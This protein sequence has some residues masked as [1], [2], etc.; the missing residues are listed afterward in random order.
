MSAL[1]IL[2]KLIKESEGCK[3]TS[4]KCPAGIWTIGYGQ[5]KGIKEGM[6]WTQNQADE[7]L[8]KSAL[9]VLNRAIKYSPIL[10]TVNMEKQ[11]AIA[12]FIYNLGVGKYATSTLKKK[13][14]VGDW[15][16]AASEIKRWDKAAGKVLKG[17]TVR[18]AKEAALLLE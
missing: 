1:E 9:E 16:S 6:V 11:A 14:D 4:Y 17:L 13:V 3:L 18:R 5:T 2:I 15:V 7:D 8:V 10:A 12:D